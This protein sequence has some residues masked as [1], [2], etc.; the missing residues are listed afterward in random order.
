MITKPIR[1]RA[2]NRKAD[3]QRPSFYVKGNRVPVPKVMVE[4]IA[5]EE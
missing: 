4:N 3:W 5:N 1:V 2:E